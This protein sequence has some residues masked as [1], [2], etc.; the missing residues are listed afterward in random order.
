M[1][2]AFYLPTISI[3]HIRKKLAM[4]YETKLRENKLELAN[5]NGVQ[6]TYSKNII[7]AFLSLHLQHL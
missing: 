5:F 2:I 1:F 4:T 6:H 3:F 7:P